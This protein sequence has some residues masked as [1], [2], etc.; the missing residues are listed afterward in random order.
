M[1]SLV[2]L[3]SFAILLSGLICDLSSSVLIC[4]YLSASDYVVPS[5]GNYWWL[6]RCSSLI[7]HYLL[8]RPRKRALFE[9]FPVSYSYLSMNL[10]KLQKVLLIFLL[11][12]LIL[13]FITIILFH[14]K[15]LYYYIVILSFI[16]L[17][18]SLLPFL[19]WS[20]KYYDLSCYMHLK[21][22]W[23]IASNSF[24]LLLFLLYFLAFSLL[25][26][27]YDLRSKAYSYFF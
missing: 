5:S 22:L 17:I 25:L 13:V 15:K 20:I 8:Y 27:L 7:H 21:N 24:F 4:F 10:R 2:F 16:S 1:G 6:S 11:L 9:S 23:I 18:V 14:S 12:V 19:I 3:S 26:L